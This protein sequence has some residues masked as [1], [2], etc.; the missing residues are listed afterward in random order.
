MNAPP[1]TIEQAT[2]YV[3][4]TDRYL[5]AQTY[6]DRHMAFAARACARRAGQSVAHRLLAA[7]PDDGKPILTNFLAGL[8]T[9]AML[10]HDTWM[11]ERAT[12]GMPTTQ[13]LRGNLIAAA[14]TGLSQARITSCA[15]QPTEAWKEMA[16]DPQLSRHP[17]PRGPIAGLICG[18]H[19]EPGDD[20]HRPSGCAVLVHVATAVTATPYGHPQDQDQPLSFGIDVPAGMWVYVAEA[21]HMASAV[22]MR[23]QDIPTVGTHCGIVADARSDQGQAVPAWPAAACW[24]TMIRTSSTIRGPS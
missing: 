22:M 24:D 2:A 19:L 14:I 5:R 17:V 6:F 16:S 8:V 20:E 9:T 7:L 11:R 13:L 3:A 1:Y 12:G 21:D 15:F 18:L 23:E 10:E 4:R